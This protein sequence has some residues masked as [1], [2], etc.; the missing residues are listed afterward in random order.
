[1]LR[2]D[3]LCPLGISF[4]EED[5]FIGTRRFMNFMRRTTISNFA[6]LIQQIIFDFMFSKRMERRDH[7]QNA[8]DGTV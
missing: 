5:F 2:I 6:F 3:I 1:M 4:R 8:L 7:G